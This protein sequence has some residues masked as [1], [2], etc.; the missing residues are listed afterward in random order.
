MAVMS[1]LVSS[2]FGDP[3]VSMAVAAG[4]PVS[5]IHLALRNALINK[6]DF[7]DEVLVLNRVYEQRLYAAFAAKSSLGFMA[8]ID[9]AN[10]IIDTSDQPASV[11][12]LPFATYRD[13]FASTQLLTAP[14]ARQLRHLLTQNLNADRLPRL[15]IVTP[16]ELNSAVETHFR[17]QRVREAVHTYATNHPEHSSRVTLQ[18]WQ[19]WF[20]GF[21]FGSGPAL[22]ILFPAASLITLH[23]F[24]WLF[25]FS[26]VALRLMA[27]LMSSNT[28]VEP[29]APVERAE[30]PQYAVLIALY[31]EADVAAQL[32][33]CLKS[34]N[35]PQTKLQV[36]LICEE[37]DAET[38]TA[39][40]AASLPANF[41]IVSVPN[42]GPRTKPKALMYTLPLVE[43]DYLVLYDAE[44][45]PHKDQLIEA[46]QMFQSSGAKT[47]CVQAPL[48]ISNWSKSLLTGLFAFEYGA[49]FR[50]LLPFLSRFNLFIPLGGTSNHFKL[51]VLREVGGWDPFNVTEDADLGLRLHRYG[52]QTKT[53]NRPTLEDAPEELRVW[54]KQRTRWFKGHMQTWMI[55]LRSPKLLISE[56]GWR[57]FFVSQIMLGGIVVSALAHP[58]LMVSMIIAVTRHLLGEPTLQIATPLAVLDL[59]N[60][61]LGYFAFMVL[62]CLCARGAEKTSIWKRVIAIPPYW[63]ILSIAAWRAL[64]QILHAPHKWEK[65]PH[66]PTV[67]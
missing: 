10:L 25:F 50:G 22:F 60:V 39:L 34:L 4:I 17:D 28:M 52:Y 18:S 27:A 43:A 33:G 38:K 2:S 26:C 41:R 32:V 66:K 49:L 16:T 62:G 36:F 47:G 40:E 6:S 61:A 23:L 45:R 13:G 48:E 12:Q 35:W 14:P 46:Y 8:D 63:F 24:A 67:D 5:E 19:G 58:I 65:T 57:S 11:R 53:I 9:P 54:T 21:V 3:L 56:I 20:F 30:L 59:I 31:H 42:Y 1:E 29:L 15:R 51:A 55:S 37:D 64:F 44:D 7:V